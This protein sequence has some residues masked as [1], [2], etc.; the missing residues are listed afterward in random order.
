MRTQAIVAKVLQKDGLLKLDNPLVTTIAL[1][2]VVLQL[3]ALKSD[4]NANEANWIDDAKSNHESRLHNNSVVA[5]KG[6]RIVQECVDIRLTNKAITRQCHQIP[7]V[8]KAVAW[9]KPMAPWSLFGSSSHFSF[10]ASCWVKDIAR[11]VPPPN[12]RYDNCPREIQVNNL[13]SQQ[14]VEWRGWRGRERTEQNA[15][16]SFVTGQQRRTIIRKFTQLKGCLL[17]WKN[18]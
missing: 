16:C 12:S 4:K 11:D 18:E 9:P 2:A 1:E 6:Y 13:R 14:K 5:P 10:I 3:N 15:V 8:R 17:T 7:I